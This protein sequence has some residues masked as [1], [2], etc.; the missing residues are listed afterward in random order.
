MKGMSEPMKIPTGDDGVQVANVDELYV[1]RINWL[2]TIGRDDLI[3]EIADDY[4][5]RR[6]TTSAAGGRSRAG[7]GRSAHHEAHRGRDVQSSPGAAELPP[8]PV[9]KGTRLAVARLR[10]S[11]SR[12]Y[13]HVLEGRSIRLGGGAR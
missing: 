1:R 12:A 3:D 10:R 5:Q 4:E 9:E 11:P 2:I 6:T 13:R 8:T 7:G